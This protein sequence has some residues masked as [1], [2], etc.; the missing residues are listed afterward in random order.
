MISGNESFF[1]ALTEYMKE[2]DVD[3]DEKYEKELQK[4][5][6][7][8]NSGFID[9]ELSEEYKRQEESDDLLEEAYNADSDKEA[10]QLAKKAIK[11]DE[12]NYDAY[13]L[14]TSLINNPEQQKKEYKKTLDMA[15]K[16]M[17]ETDMF[18]KDNIGSF[19]GIIE[20]RPYMRTRHSYILTLIALG[21]IEDALTECEE[22]LKLCEND[23]MGIRYILMRLYVIKRDYRAA[24]K[25]FKVYNESSIQMLFPMSIIH[26]YKGE[27]NLAKKSLEEA[28]MRNEHIIKCITKKIELSLE[29]IADIMSERYYAWGSK[30]EVIIL[31]V[32]YA[33]L[34]FNSPDYLFWLNENFNK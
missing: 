2:K 10:I 6:E 30:E 27:Y 14:I 18:S 20:T 5:T 17:E 31:L 29:E 11:V 4:F 3:T 22:M 21:Q 15:T 28:A 9:F 1:K 34:L 24:S 19:W 8:Y 13:N 16:H 25:L 23:N 7:M 33:D 26:Y 32:E 12:H